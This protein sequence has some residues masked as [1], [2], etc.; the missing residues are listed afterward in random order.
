MPYFQSGTEP[1][2]KIFYIDRGEGK[3]VLFLIHGWYQNARDCFSYYIDTF[4]HSGRVVAVD[5]PGHGS[6]FKHKSGEYSLISA[7]R[8]CEELL[9]RVAKDAS[10][11]T[12]VGHS[13]GSFIGVKLAL[14]HAN[15]VTNLILISPILDFGPYEK[16]LK[17]MMRIPKFMHP[18]YLRWQSFRDGF[19]FGD[20]KYIYAQEKGHKIPGKNEYY[21]IKTTNHPTFI[22]RQYARSFP[23]STVMN[24]IQNVGQP[25]LI[26]Y[27]SEDRLTPPEPGT[28]IVNMLPRG[29]LRIIDRGGHN[30]Q[31]TRKEETIQLIEEFLEEH[32]RK[33]WS[34]RRLFGRKS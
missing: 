13:M 9:T 12:I 20:R 30:V 31:L 11:I 7:Y 29:L 34:W 4:Q 33:R 3:E 6:S 18:A 25:V 15:L 1:D 28:A 5:L 8:A 19:P 22:A 21:R 2:Q 26:L 24:L 16:R 14:L 23:K 32:K 17:R 27:G 10:H